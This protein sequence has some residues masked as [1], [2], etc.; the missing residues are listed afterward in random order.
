MKGKP[1]SKGGRRSVDQ[2]ESEVN[3]EAA[4]NAQIVV[5][6]GEWANRHDEARGSDPGVKVQ[7]GIKA[8]GF[9]RQ[10]NEA[11]AQGGLTVQS[12]IKAGGGF[13]NHSE[14]RT[15]GGL[16]VQSGIKAGFRILNHNEILVT[17][18]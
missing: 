1:G 17:E 8:G 3:D 13:T 10:H 4:E 14:A 5:E 15:E 6:A 7:S 12:G 9:E 18:A 2:N 16:M 11:Q